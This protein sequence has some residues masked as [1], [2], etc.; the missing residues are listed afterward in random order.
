MWKA[1]EQV[2]DEAV[3]DYLHR[4]AIPNQSLQQFDARR[5][6][7]LEGMEIGTF[8]LLPGGVSQ[9]AAGDGNLYTIDSSRQYALLGTLPLQ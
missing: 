7:F 2:K 6:V 3:T 5:L 1:V 8:L 9:A 4:T